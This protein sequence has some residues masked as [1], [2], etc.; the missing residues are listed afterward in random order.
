MKKVVG[1]MVLA[2]MVASFAS[3]SCKAG[4]D[5]DTVYIPYTPETKDSEK[6]NKAAEMAHVPVITSQPQ[7]ATYTVGTSDVNPLRVIAEV[8]DGGKLEYQWYQDD[9]EISGATNKSFTPDVSATGKHDYNCRVTN[10][11]GSSIREKFSDYAKIIVQAGVTT[12]VAAIP[13]I[14]AKSADK[15][16]KSEENTDPISVTATVT[17]SENKLAGT[18]SYQWFIDGVKLPGATNYIYEIG[19]AENVDSQTTHK[20]YCEVTNTANDATDKTHIS[21][22][23]KSGEIII[24]IIPKYYDLT[25]AASPVI[26]IDPQGAI[27]SVDEATRPDVSPLSV[28]ATVED[29]GLEKAG[30]LSYQWYKADNTPVEDATSET[31]QPFHDGKAPLVESETAYSYYCVVTNTYEQATDTNHKIQTKK[32]AVAT[33]TVKPLPKPVTPTIPADKNLSETAS[34][35]AKVM[36]SV[37]AKVTDGGT[38][39]YQWY[40]DGTPISEATNSSYEANESGKY[41]VEVTN[42]LRGFSTKIKSNEC[43]VT[44]GGGSNTGDAGIDIDFN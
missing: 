3:V 35:E 39:S 42:S 32:S 37:E 30:A 11:L 12:T 41:Y 15:T 17:A 38:I 18:L 2:A 20:Y 44:I 40:K 13:E 29:N 26:T 43:T 19:K 33:I 34:G 24:K 16:Y 8:T 36:L 22:T 5:G 4:E 9:V 1:F 21:E 10:T 6:E 25:S 23:V 27:Y 14:T 31:F 28:A 7:G